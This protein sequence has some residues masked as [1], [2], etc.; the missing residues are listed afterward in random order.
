[1]SRPLFSCLV[2][3]AALSALFSVQPLPAGENAFPLFFSPSPSNLGAL[4]QDMITPFQVEI[5]N[6]SENK[7]SVRIIPTCGCL[8][9]EVLELSLD[10]GEKKVLELNYDTTGTRGQFENYFIIKIDAPYSAKALYTVTGSVKSG[11]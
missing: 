9:T 5:G 7:V 8:G 10:P 4:E 6:R 1:M 2:I 11:L 3:L